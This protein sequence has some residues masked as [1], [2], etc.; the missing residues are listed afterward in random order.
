MKALLAANANPNL[1]DEGGWTPLHLA[2]LLGRKE[3]MRILLAAG[4]NPCLQSSEK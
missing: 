1:Q 3:I 4:A 2:E